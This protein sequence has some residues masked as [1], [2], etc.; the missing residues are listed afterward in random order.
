MDPDEYDRL[1]RRVLWLLPS[2]LY[3]LGSSA[4]VDGARR[5]NLM[6]ANL[7]LQVC[8]QPKL[9]AAAVEATSVTAGLV[10]AGGAFSV[11]V[12]ERDDRAVVRR[13]VKP[14]AEVVR[15]PDGAPVAMNGHPVRAT[16]AGPPVLE[17]APAWL[18]CTV[19]EELVLGSHVLFVG[20]VAD[21]GGPP[22]GATVLP[23]RMEDTRMNYG[24]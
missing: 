2:G 12:L 6:T 16:G 10:R 24:G 14:V 5:D 19:V 23:L 7:V 11:S 4:T 17:S 3:L 18:A 1:R 9:V 21:V 22:P 8:L 15:G 20:E 13:F